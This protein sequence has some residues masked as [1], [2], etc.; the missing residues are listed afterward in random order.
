MR[1]EGRHRFPAP[2][3]DTA[4]AMTDPEFVA[5]LVAVPD[6]GDVA[7]LDAGSDDDERWVAARFRYDGSLDPIAAR[8]LGSSS[9]SWV[10]TYRMAIDGAAGSLVIEPDH[11]GSLLT[12]SARVSA[13]P[14]TDGGT[15]RRLDGTLSVRVPLLG[16]RAEKA[17]GPAILSR[18]D[19]EA[20]LL[21]AWLARP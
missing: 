21:T 12:C 1:I 16:G 14:T 2:P 5:G 13:E 3:Q 8:V 11:H 20:E 7:V 17:L 9:P 6:V 15:D 10:Q 4:A 18:I 19:V